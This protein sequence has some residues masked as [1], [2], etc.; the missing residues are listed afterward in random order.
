MCAKDG[1]TFKIPTDFLD[2]GNNYKMRLWHGGNCTES[3][4]TG[5]NEFNIAL[6]SNDGFVAILEK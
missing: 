2:K 1:V 4:F 3:N 6:S 5:G